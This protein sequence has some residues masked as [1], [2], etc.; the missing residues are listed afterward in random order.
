[1]RQKRKQIQN[2]MF[3][4][5]IRPKM[6][7]NTRR[8]VLYY[9]PTHVHKKSSCFFRSEKSLKSNDVLCASRFR[10]DK[11][12]IQKHTLG[13]TGPMKTNIKWSSGWLV[14]DDFQVELY[15]NTKIVIW[16]AVFCTK[17]NGILQIIYLF[18][19]VFD[20]LVKDL[21]I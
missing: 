13:V 1:M 5:G 4:N 17:Y 2:Y 11:K 14:W 6:K 20:H 8:I 18:S 16:E 21:I 15:R 7:E 19:E 3:F 12:N 10:D 9:A